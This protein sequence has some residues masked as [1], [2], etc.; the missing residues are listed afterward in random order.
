MS[1]FSFLKNIFVTK[2]SPEQYDSYVPYLL[3]RWFS[4][5]NPSVAEN[6]NTFNKQVF[7]ENK[8]MHFKIL[9]TIFPKTK[10][11]PNVYYIKKEKEKQLDT[12]SKHI[13]LLAKR[14]ELSVNE[15]TKLLAQARIVN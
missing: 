6:I 3:N 13:E 2:E 5:I 1:P 10:K 9:A 11:V 8:D 12:D 7:L 14:Y 15:T 4:F